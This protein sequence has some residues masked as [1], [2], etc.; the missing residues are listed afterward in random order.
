M[1]DIKP[2]RAVRPRTA[3]AA[4]CSLKRNYRKLQRTLKVIRKQ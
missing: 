1:A 4:V 2:F 3:Y